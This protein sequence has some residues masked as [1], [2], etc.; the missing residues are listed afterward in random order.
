MYFCYFDESGDSGRERS[1]TAAFVLSGVL[2]NDRQWLAAL[3]E[4]TEFRRDLRDNFGIP[5]RMELKAAWLLHNKKDIR[6]CGLSFSARMAA[7]KA[8]MEF[9]RKSE[10]FRTFAALVRKDSL[11]REHCAHDIAW[12]CALSVLQNLGE[13]ENENMHILPDEGYGGFIRKLVGE[14]RQRHRA[15]GQQ[16]SRIIED[17]SDR[18]SHESYFVQLAD[19]NAYAAFRK[20]FPGANVDGQLWDALG[21]CRIQEIGEAGIKMLP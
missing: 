19:L 17:P 6:K 7:Y 10:N 1:P 5:P 15:S 8:A 20:V 2:V 21:D 14:I 4:I 11:P 16:P 12:R 18:K 3:D 9:Q 13:K